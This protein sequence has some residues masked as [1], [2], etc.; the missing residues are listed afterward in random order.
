VSPGQP[1]RRGQAGERHG[2]ERGRHANPDPALEGGGG[3]L[4]A[5]TERL[6]TVIGSRSGLIYHD[7]P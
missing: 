6:S 5:A 7:L 2:N 4:A 3:R 1:Q